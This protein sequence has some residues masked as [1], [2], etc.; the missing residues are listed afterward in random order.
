MLRTISADRM[1]R[2]RACVAG[3]GMSADEAD[4]KIRALHSILCTFAEASW[5]IDPVSQALSARA[6]SHFRGIEHD[7]TMQNSIENNSVDLDVEGVSN[8]PCP[9][10]LN[11]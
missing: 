7:A 4:E 5:G 10:G 3:L 1:D 2:Y 6:N 8:E 11:T 9:R